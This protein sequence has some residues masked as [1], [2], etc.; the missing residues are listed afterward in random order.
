MSSVSLSDQSHATG[1][2]EGQQRFISVDVSP[3]QSSREA[4]FADARIDEGLH[5]LQ[6]EQEPA[7]ERNHTT[8]WTFQVQ[9]LESKDVTRE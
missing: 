7:E 2:R 5:R 9:F 3:A 4:G 1:T 6:S 8:G